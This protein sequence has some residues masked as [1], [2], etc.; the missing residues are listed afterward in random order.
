MKT[1]NIILILVLMFCL[2]LISCELNNLDNTDDFKFSMEF[3]DG[4]TINENDVAFYDTTTSIL[5]INSKLN[6]IVGT[7]ETPEI[8]ILTFFLM[9]CLLP[10]FG[11]PVQLIQH[12]K[13]TYSQ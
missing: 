1:L 8:C 5:F 6:L 4:T 11:F 10:I 3:S 12:L 9:L 13:V 7:G 2:Y